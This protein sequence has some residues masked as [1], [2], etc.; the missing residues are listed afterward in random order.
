[1]VINL[2]NFE[3]SIEKIAKCKA[4]FYCLIVNYRVLAESWLSL[5]PVSLFLIC[6]NQMLL[7]LHI[8]LTRILLQSSLEIPLFSGLGRK[9]IPQNLV[10]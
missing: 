5:F 10:H 6:T 1:M 3:L 8:D 4:C 9:K 7:R 2:C